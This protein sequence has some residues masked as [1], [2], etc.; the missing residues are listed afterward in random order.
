MNRKSTWGTTLGVCAVILVVWWFVSRKTIMPSPVAAFQAAVTAEPIHLREKIRVD[1]NYEQPWRFTPPGGK[2][3]GRF[4]GH[5]S[6]RGKTAGISGAH[7][8]TLVAFTLVG[9]D[10]R[11]IQ[12][13]DHP[14]D[15]NFD[16]RLD[17]PGGY[18]FMF[19]NCGIL[20]SSAR[21]VQFE[22][23]YQPD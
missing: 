19:N 1:A 12:K 7:D 20:R 17:G 10:N 14:T 4:T 8:D 13:L 6:C 15:G 23:T 11:T 2:Y 22:G 3:P 5:W 16:I 18:T 9:P 21:V